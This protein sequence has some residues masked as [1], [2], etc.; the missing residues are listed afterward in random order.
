LARIVLIRHGQTEW[1]REERFRGRV[2]IDLDEMGSR[3]AEAA[4]QRIAQWE[5][6]AIYSSP[7]KRALATAGIIAKRLGLPVEPLDGIND[8]DFGVWQG[9]SVSEA[10]EKYPDLFDLWRYSP[11]RLKIPE[12]ESLEDVQNRV[13]ATINDLA[14]RYENETVALVT[15]RVVCK[16][17]LCHLLGLDNSHFWQIAQDATAINTFEVRGGIPTVRLINDTCHLRAL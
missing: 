14:A 10:R 11:Q 13:D 17:L 1:N 15:H 12:G 4:A 8:M 7:L 6:A 16:V 9:L 2:D 5:V 3:Q